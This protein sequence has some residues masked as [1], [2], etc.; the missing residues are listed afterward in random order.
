MD[1]KQALKAFRRR[2]FA[3]SMLHA[4]IG[5]M[6]AALSAGFLLR[7]YAH[8]WPN[9]FPGFAGWGVC[10]LIC[11][12]LAATLCT[13]L[14]AWPSLPRVAKRVDALGLEERMG[15]MV[16]FCREDAAACR[17]Q[18]MDALN[19]LSAIHPRQ[20]RILLPRKMLCLC[21]ALSL[22]LLSIP[23]LPVPGTAASPSGETEEARLIHGLLADLEQ[24]ILQADL[25]DEERAMLLEQLAALETDLTGEIEEIEALAAMEEASK[26]IQNQL[27]IL[28]R[29]G[30]LLENLIA[31]DWFRALGEAIQAGDSAMVRASF[32]A[33]EAEL[34]GMDD[35]ALHAAILEIAEA[36]DTVTQQSL[37]SQEEIYLAH[38]L[39]DLGTDLKRI[40]DL[41]YDRQDA[42]EIIHAT[43]EKAYLA[44]L[45]AM[46]GA[47]P[48]D[49]QADVPKEEG[50]DESG[51]S[52]TASEEAGE[53]SDAAGDVAVLGDT[54][55]QMGQGGVSAPDSYHRE[56]QTTS[57]LVYEPTM[58]DTFP[59]KSYVQGSADRQGGVQRLVAGEGET[60]GNVPYSQ[61]FGVYYADLLEQ[62][63]KDTIPDALRDI[64]E[65][66][67]YGL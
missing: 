36:T 25:S 57:V 2:I 35:A 17:L 11:L 15:T 3:E 9:A 21:L 53:A 46:A 37:I 52:A 66:Y 16:R 30:S 33:M 28:E 48:D 50:A 64:V 62:L 12:S 24:Q 54:L 61:V 43:L 29:Y 49:A 22:A 65:A 5:G 27:Q 51:M 4:L 7:L 58:D 63:S 56:R 26:R 34:I 32:Q 45:Q 40:V 20:L 8:L 14:S 19:K 13:L 39:K 60:A 59:G 18:R 1:A 42:E 55:R 44:V 41:D 10:L 23:L 31:H 6:A 38:A 67:L 47:M